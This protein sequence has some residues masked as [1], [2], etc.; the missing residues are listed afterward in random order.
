MQE[1]QNFIEKYNKE[2][3]NKMSHD[4][5]PFYENYIDDIRAMI[6]EYNNTVPD[7]PK[8]DEKLFKFV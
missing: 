3:S 8:K 1:S 6:T 5:Y 2:I 4:F 7:G